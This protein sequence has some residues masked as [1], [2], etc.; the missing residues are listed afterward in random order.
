[1]LHGALKLPQQRAVARIEATDEPIEE[2]PPVRGGPGEEAV[3]GRKQPDHL[4]VL[5]Q[6]TGA[7]LHRPVDVHDA[8]GIAARVIGA[9]AFGR[10]HREGSAD[11]ERAE[12]RD[13]ARSDG[14]ALRPHSSKL[15][16]GRAP[17][18]LP[19]CQQGD[20]L[21]QVGFAGT[22]GA[23][24]N[25]RARPQVELQAAIIAKVGE[26]QSLDP[27]TGSG[28]GRRTHPIGVGRAHR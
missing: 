26:L 8:T 18:S 19:R 4:D 14:P 11:V 22:I 1:M 15:W 20:G 17:Q 16:I 6:D 28:A 5:R 23:C 10:A 21:Q 9:P 24:E 27:N 12:G 13:K 3:H 2:A 25:D 7:R